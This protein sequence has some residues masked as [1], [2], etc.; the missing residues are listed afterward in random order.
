MTKVKVGDVSK[1]VELRNKLNC[2]G[3]RWYLNNIFPES[4]IIPSFDK[5]GQIQKFGSK[6]CLDR[7]G[8]SRNRQIGIHKCH[9]HG[10][11]QG[12]A[13]QK[14]KQ[15]VF[16][17]SKCL[18][19]AQQEKP[20]VPIALNQK[21]VFMKSAL[22]NPKGLAGLNKL[23]NLKK[24]KNLVPQLDPIVLNETSEFIEPALVNPNQLT[25]LNRQS[26]LKSQKRVV[27]QEP[28][29]IVP[30]HVF[31]KPALVNANQLANL[32]KL[33]YIKK[34][35]IAVPQKLEPIDLNETNA[36]D[37]TVFGNPKQLTDLNQLAAFKK[38]KNAAAQEMVPIVPNRKSAFNK[39]AL[40]DLKESQNL[41][42]TNVV[43]KA[44]RVNAKKLRNLNK[45][46]NLKKGKSV[47][48][49]E[50]AEVEEEEEIIDLDDP[51]FLTPEIN[52]SNHVVLLK[53]NATNGDKWNY[54]EAVRKS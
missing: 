4:V 36:F 3:F 43:F 25:N 5:I 26:N 29:P 28:A 14:N 23:A 31:N 52:T 6:Y 34:Q 30:Q 41:N 38:Q 20:V 53:C 44:A 12:F 49:Q 27:P 47:V 9:G 13:L 15:I 50:L 10:Y 40:T 21:V 51:D 32:N 18:S 39:S 54:I 19:R 8:R 11:S 48:P 42:E 16:H 24:S 46:A 2:K 1:R 17:H 37:K 7:L 45:V 22:V 35:T 33:A